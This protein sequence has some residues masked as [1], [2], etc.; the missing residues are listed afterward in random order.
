[1]SAPG[2]NGRAPTAAAALVPPQD[3]GA[4][5]A[6][7]GAILLTDRALYAPV[8][9]G[10]RSE[11]FYRPRH[12]RIFAA[13]LELDAERDAGV[14]ALTVCDRLSQHGAL[15]EVGGQAYVHSLPT[16]VPALGNVSHYARIVREKALYRQTLRVGHELERAIYAQEAPAREL[17][18]RA[19]A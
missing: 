11:H 19:I 17:V 8:L 16:L 15:E 12:G 1:M 5:V 14:D 6:V 3:D 4:E 7:L 9:V 18:E 13:M 2:T 10:L